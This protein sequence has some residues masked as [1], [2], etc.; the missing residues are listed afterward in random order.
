M[1]KLLLAV[2]VMASIAYAGDSLVW[3]GA[4]SGVMDLPGNW[5]VGIAGAAAG[6]I[7]TDDTLFVLSGS[8][9]ITAP[10]SDLTVARMY[11]D[12]GYTGASI[13][14]SG[15]VLTLA[16]LKASAFYAASAY[17]FG[18]GI[19][20]SGA[21]H[22]LTCGVGMGSV[23]AT[24]CAVTLNG[25]DTVTDNK[26]LVIASITT[27][28]STSCVWNGTGGTPTYITVPLI[29]LGA[30]SSLQMDETFNQVLTASGAPIVL[31]SG[32]TLTGTGTSNIRFNASGVK[33]TIPAVTRN[34]LI[35]WVQNY[36][37]YSLD[38][39]LLN[40]NWNLGT[41][42]ARIGISATSGSIR[43]DGNGYGITCGI[44]RTYTGNAV[45]TFWFV[46][47]SGTYSVTNFD[48][49]TSGTGIT[50]D[51]MGSSVWNCSGNWT[52]FSN[53]K[54]IAGTS[55]VNITGTS[56]V[57]S[58]AQSF[59]KFVSNPG[60]EN[61]V[62]FA[63]NF[64]NTDT[65]FITS[66][67]LTSTAGNITTKYLSTAGAGAVTWS[68]KTLTTTNGMNLTHTGTSNLGNGITMSGNGALVFGSGIGAVTG[69]SCAI[70]CN[71]I[72]TITD[73]KGAAPMSLAVNENTYFGGSATEIFSSATIPLTIAANKM[74]TVA[75]S[76][77]L[78]F[79]R[80]T[81]GYLVTM[82]D[83]ASINLGAGSSF[84][85]RINAHVKDTLPAMNFTGTGTVTYYC[86]GDAPTTDFLF[87]SG[88]QSTA[89][90]L[91]ILL[92]GTTFDANG[93]N[94]NC[95]G[96]F[97]TSSNGD[98][99]KYYLRN[100]KHHFKIFSGIAGNTRTIYCSTS[101]DT[102]SGSITILSNTT[103]NA[104]ASVWIIDS[105]STVTSNGKWFYDFTINNS[106]SG[107]ITLADSLR[108][109]GDVTI[110][111]GPF[112]SGTKYMR[113]VDFTVTSTDSQD[114]HSSH[115]AIFG[116]MTLGAGLHRNITGTYDT[117]AAGAA[118][119]ITTNGNTLASVVGLGRLAI[120]GGSTIA[121]LTLA[122]GI[123]VTLEKGLKITLTAGDSTDLSG[124]AGALD[125][126]VSSTAGTRDTLS[127]P[128]G[129][130][131]Y[132]H[133]CLK[134]QDV[135]NDTIFLD[136]TCRTDGN[137]RG[138]VKSLSYYAS[139][140]FSLPS[141]IRKNDTVRITCNGGFTPTGN[142]VRIG[143]DTLLSVTRTSYKAAWGIAPAAI[144]GKEL[145]TI[146]N[147]DLDTVT[148]YSRF[149]R[150]DRNSSSNVN[151]TTNPRR[152]L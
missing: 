69:T 139:S 50:Y 96:T 52:A 25:T 2:M 16:G 105:T 113:M 55:V 112:S 10:A 133:L 48:G 140:T 29:T 106:G 64:I 79:Y 142:H 102:V 1:K 138:V 97:S 147:S 111:D 80:T 11:V 63:D 37:G 89:G 72:D 130:N 30:N 5:T 38:T 17:N 34:S 95:G 56:S 19:T 125:T 110:T 35:Y 14:W 99:A 151:I 78:R 77:V 47:G 36:A 75:A 22:K 120:N 49:V 109:S 91:T 13:S 7:D 44:F 62:T 24:S 90:A 6:S 94:I 124:S 145:V 119:T 70:T 127:I 28:A 123:K 32:A 87:L 8:V 101:F 88:N 103:F 67:S 141:K 122:D 21:S 54:M 152:D 107:F 114:Y 73:N 115:R 117:F 46:A 116:D 143:S 43:F 85:L 60:A 15:K 58:A 104:D 20:F 12:G 82:G 83:G 84:Q 136:S 23:T 146:R 65:L 74:L 59:Y 144:S 126:I 86:A 98:G 132:H 81:A 61:T 33:A 42:M 3:T 39:L 150:F 76:A 128:T 148:L 31:G 121:R 129:A 27:A 118:H 9:A 26:G 135:K 18:N 149:S 131:I 92:T 100:G 40:G 51:S 41:Q 134:D 4:T 66:G 137:N 71:G 108:D 68:G 53:D 45:D 57:T 93:Y